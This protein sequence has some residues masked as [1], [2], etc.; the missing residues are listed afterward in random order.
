MAEEINSDAVLAV[1]RRPRKTIGQE[2]S[3][4]QTVAVLLLSLVLG[5]F[6]YLSGQPRREPSVPEPVRPSV[7]P[8][9]KEKVYTFIKPSPS[10]RPQISKAAA[11]TALNDLLSGQAGD[12]SV[13]SGP[14]SGEEMIKIKENQVLT[15]ASVIK[16]PV[17]V[18]YYQA[19][20][21]G[22][23]NP[24]EEYVLVEA[25]RWEYGT[26]SMQYQ[27]AGTKYT[28]RQIARLV[29]NQSDNMGMEVIIRKLGGYAKTQTAVKAL[30]MI[31]TNLRE[32]ETTAEE[33]GNL[34]IQLAKGK[35]LSADSRKELFANLTKTINEDRLP[36]GVPEN[37]RVIHKFGS[38]SGVVNDCG[39]VEAKKPYVICILSNN[40]NAGE[41]EALMSQISKTIWSWLGQ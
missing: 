17:L 13:Y 10:V 28:Y 23:L 2:G 5:L 35:L 24:D 26:G 34:L 7:R 37:I 36:A 32:N 16:L 18:V 6:F 3:R 25:D 41:A 1:K 12:W 14:V 11:E 27:P 29:A 4:K 39:I 15:A 33:T 8:S 40:V 9:I 30:G 31:K 38:E 21:K 20:D 22:S 19:V